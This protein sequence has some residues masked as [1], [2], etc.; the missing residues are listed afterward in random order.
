[1]RRRATQT[2]LRVYSNGNRVLHGHVDGYHHISKI[3]NVQGHHAY[4][5]PP[6]ED[7]EA[8]HP[9]PSGERRREDNHS[10]KAI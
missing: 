2:F 9:C 4:I 5:Y 3:R 1:M 10:R 7:E 8:I 6:G